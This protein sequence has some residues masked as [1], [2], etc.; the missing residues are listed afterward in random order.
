MKGKALGLFMASILILCMGSN[1]QAHDRSGHD[2]DLEYV[3]FGNEQYKESHPA[4]SHVIQAL[5]DAAYL[6]VDQFNGHGQDDLDFLKSEKIPDLPE[7]IEAIDFT[8][9]YAHRNYTHR[10]WNVLYPEKS[11]WQ[12]RRAI[13]LN[14]IEKELFENDTPL[15]WFPWLSDVVYGSGD[16][17]EK[18]E[19]FGVLIYYVHIIGDH[20]EAEK[21][22]ALGYV[23]PLT[24]MNDRDNPGVIPDLIKYLEIL[25][26]EQKGSYTYSDFMQEM[27]VLQDRSDKLTGSTGGVNTEEKFEEYHKCANDLREVLSIYVPILLKNESYFYD[28]F[29]SRNAA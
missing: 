22:D 5:E 28:V 8:G 3:L 25:F 21:Y 16:N 12:E 20:L 26:E 19:S 24:N 4:V 9:N 14:T 29:F 10:G 11:H 27:E 15:D 23:A 18:I 17:D 2:A 7:S 6:C 1:V 13:L